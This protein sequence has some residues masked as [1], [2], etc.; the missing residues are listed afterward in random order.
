MAATGQAGSGACANTK[1]CIG[2]PERSGDA[3]SSRESVAR[4]QQLIAVSGSGLAQELTPAPP[5]IVS[6]GVAVDGR[7]DVVA[8]GPTKDAHDAVPGNRDVVVVGGAGHALDSG[9]VVGHRPTCV[10]DSVDGDDLDPGGGD[11]AV[12]KGV[13]A[14]APVDLFVP[15]P[16]NRASAPSPPASVSSA[17][18]AASA[19]SPRRTSAPSPPVR[20]S[21]N[22]PPTSLL[23]A[24]SPMIVLAWLAAPVT[25]SR[26][27]PSR[28]TLG[29]RRRR[30]PSTDRPRRPGWPWGSWR[31]RWYRRRR[32][33]R[34]LPTRRSSRRCRPRRR[35]C[36]CPRG[37]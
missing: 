10:P 9:E 36:R 20:S 22:R 3:R 18:V 32:R 14:R 2:G 23:L 6:E 34:R 1:E 24:S 5:P 37:R 7:E 11:E 13:R 33:A 27:R 26:W 25:R 31:C 29:R 28:R 8:A 35:A 21:A 15:S 17:P 30:R 19:A 4:A 16:G 12:P